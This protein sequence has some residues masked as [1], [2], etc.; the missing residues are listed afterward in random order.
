[1]KDLKYTVTS[2]ARECGFDL[3]GI[4]GAEDFASDRDAALER[5]REGRMEGLPWYTESRVMRG[6]SPSEL[7]P[8]AQSVI[9]LG[10][11]LL[12]RA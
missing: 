8:G 2:L 10:A 1:M 7:L 3:V 6:T 5:L 4:A 11:E 12:G 9:C